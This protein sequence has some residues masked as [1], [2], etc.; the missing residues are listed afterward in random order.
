MPDR[1]RSR[2]VTEIEKGWGSAPREGIAI[3]I[4]RGLNYAVLHVY[5]ERE[6]GSNDIIQAVKIRMPNKIGL[7]GAYVSPNISRQHLIILYPQS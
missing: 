5:N 4:Q 7:N 1:E 3:A 6:Q 2:E